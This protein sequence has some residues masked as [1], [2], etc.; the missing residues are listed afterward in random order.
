LVS[1]PA[2]RRADLD[3]LKRETIADIAEACD[4]DSVLASRH[5]RRFA[6]GRHP[7]G[8]AVVGN[9]RSVRAVTRRDVVAHHARHFVQDNL[10]VGAAGAVTADRFLKLV[11]EHLGGVPAGRAPRERVSPPRMKRGRR[12]LIVDKPERTQT[13]VIIGTLGVRAHERDFFPFVVGNTVFGGT[14]TARLMNEIRSKRGWS[15]GT[16]SRL[17]KDRQRDLW[18]MWAFPAAADAPECIALQLEMLEALLDRGI[19]HKELAFARRYLVKSHAF[20][21]DTAAKRLGLFID[22]ELLSLRRSFYLN[23]EERVRSVTR[24]SVNASLRRRLSR[25]DLAIAMVATA[26]EI[27]PRVADL[28]G[29]ERV[30]TVPY[31]AAL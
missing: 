11:D 16:G 2:L 26:A 28:P 9:A 10:I 1:R 23:F 19:T 7:Y 4:H 31:R 14:F 20:D 21:I 17:S 15:Y 3:F 6:L 27:R 25:R 29:I 5:F 12:L 22:A 18:S 13:Q 24:D 30:T 8:R